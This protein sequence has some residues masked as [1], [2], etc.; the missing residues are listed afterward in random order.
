VSKPVLSAPNQEWSLDFVHDA[1]A[2]GQTVRVLSVVDTFTR[3]CLALETDTSFASE[4]VTRILDGLIERRACPL[5]LRM[6]N[7]LNA[8]G[9][10]RVSAEGLSSTQRMRAVAVSGFEEAGFPRWSSTNTETPLTIMNTR[11]A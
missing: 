6:D 8:S 10:F 9:K 5:A 2:T 7:G 4:R 1:L 11:S 3:E